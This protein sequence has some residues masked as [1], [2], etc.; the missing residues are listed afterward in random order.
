[1][2]NLPRYLG[3]FF[4]KK[5]SNLLFLVTE[6]IYIYNRYFVFS[7]TIAHL[8]FDDY[9]CICVRTYIDGVKNVQKAYTRRVCRKCMK[10]NYATYKNRL[11][12]LNRKTIEIRI[13]IMSL[14]MFYNIFHKHVACNIHDPFTAPTNNRNLRG[15]H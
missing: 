12:Y 2:S 9:T 10:P 14:T 3:T 4:R 1:M 7:P 11:A 15:Q 6:Y 8:N 5:I 13:Y